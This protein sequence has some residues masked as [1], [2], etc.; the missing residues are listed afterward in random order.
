M[1]MSRP[2]LASIVLFLLPLAASSEPVAEEKLQG[3]WRDADRKSLIQFTQD[4]T[5]LWWGKTIEAV[6]KKE[7][8]KVVFRKLVYDAKT[9]AFTGLM[10]KPDD[11]DDVTMDVTVTLVSATSMTAVVKK[12]IFSKTL[13]LTKEAPPPEAKK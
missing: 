10:I 13:S 5:G 1:D 12:F 11:D 9:G 4:A 7:A 6:Q 2:L 3:T 8:G